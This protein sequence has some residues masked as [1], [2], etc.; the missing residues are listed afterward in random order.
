MET[1]RM[2]SCTT[3]RRVQDWQSS[4]DCQSF[5]RFATNQANYLRALTTPPPGRRY[6]YMYQFPS[7]ISRLPALLQMNDIIVPEFRV[8]VTPP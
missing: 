5:Q 8:L 2:E 4:N 1:G 7:Q 6:E 3:N